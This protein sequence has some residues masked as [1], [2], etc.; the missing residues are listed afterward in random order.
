VEAAK[1]TLEDPIVRRKAKQH[2]DFDDDDGDEDFIEE[3]DDYLDVVDE[4]PE[5]HLMK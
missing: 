4:I 2:A 5:R 3:I 1:R